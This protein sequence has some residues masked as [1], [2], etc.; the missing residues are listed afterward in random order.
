[1]VLRAL[2]TRVLTTL[3]LLAA[4]AAPARA[5]DT[6][7]DDEVRKTIESR[8]VTINFPDTGI[9]DIVLFLQDI[10]GLTFLLDPAIDPEARVTLKVRDM[11]LA[12]AL[13]HIVAALGPD[14]VREVWLGTVYISSRKAPKPV[15]P[16]PDLPEE[17]RKALREKKVTVNF[18]ETPIADAAQFLS[19]IQ[20]EGGVRV[21]VAAGVE[22]KVDLRM[23]SAPLGDVLAVICR[24]HGLVAARDGDG[25]VLRKR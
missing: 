10:T 11:T 25:I 17:R 24:L 6:R 4:L 16:E 5:G 1:M 19:D 8:R 22:G 3:A 21:A 15:P 2:S 20:G 14:A 13:D 9:A 12:S 23:K 7:T 18:A